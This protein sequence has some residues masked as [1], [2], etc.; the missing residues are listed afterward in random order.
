MNYVIYGVQNIYLINMVK[1]SIII[2]YFMKNEYI[3]NT[4]NITPGTL[5]MSKLEKRTTSEQFIKDLHTRCKILKEYIFSGTS[6]PGEA[7]KRR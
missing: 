2:D 5:F 4:G 7:K 1:I 3:W 6:V